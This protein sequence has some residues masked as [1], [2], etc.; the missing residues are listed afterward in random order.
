MCRLW[1]KDEG[2]YSWQQYLLLSMRRSPKR[3]RL[4]SS[5]TRVREDVLAEGMTKIVSRLTLPDDRRKRVLALLQD[6]D[7]IESIRAKRTWLEEKLRR[8]RRAWIEVEIDEAY[9]RKERTETESRL[10]GLVIPDGVVNIGEAAKPFYDMSATWEAASREERRAILGF[11]LE[12][13]YCDPAEE[14]V[15]ALRPKDKFAPL[16]NNM[17]ILQ[18]KGHKFETG[19]V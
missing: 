14:V 6:V 3:N 10:A 11:I 9:Y 8:L 13:I 19:W 18:E 4:P 17:A 2:R 16:F 12:A 7:E 1:W 5:Q 15:I